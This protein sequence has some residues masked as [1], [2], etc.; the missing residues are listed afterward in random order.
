ME[1]LRRRIVDYFGSFYFFYSYLRFKV[2]VI[3]FLSIL[4]GVL[5]GFGLAMFIPLL[6]MVDSPDSS[7]VDQLGNLSF[8]ITW[9]SEL[10]IPFNLYSILVTI[11]IFFGLKG[12]VKFLEGYLR[13]VY[14]Q[15]FIRQIRVQNADDLA[16]FKYLS[17]I[18]S[19]NGRIQN[20]FSAEVG[21]VNYAFGAYFGALQSAIMVAVYLALAFLTNA[22]F[23]I[24]ISIGGGV[25]NL[26]FKRLYKSTKKASQEYT[27]QS[28]R[29]QGLLIQKVA[30]FKYLKATGLIFKYSEKLK[31]RIFLM[32]RL[33]RRMGILDT[34]MQAVREPLI[35]LV[36]VTVIMI[37]VKFFSEALG[38]IIL[39]LLLFYRALSF[40]MSVQKQWNSFLASS[41]AL[42]NMTKFISE[43][44]NG[45]E[46]YGETILDD[47]TY[48]LELKDIKFSYADIEVLKDIN[49][50]IR[51]NETI[52]LVGESGSGKTTLINLIAGLI[53]P[54]GGEI[55]IDNKPYT[56]LDVRSV[57]SR[58]GYITQE[59]VIF[60][61]TVFNNVTFWDEPT[62]YNIL[63]FE[64]CLKKAAI[65][66]FIMSLD[67]K[68]NTTLGING[69]NL[70]G[71][72]KQRLSIARELYKEIDLLLM[73]EATSALDSETE[74]IIQANI[75][76][77]KG[78][79][80]IIIIAHRLSTIKN[81][82]R[83]VM[84]NRGVIDGVGE[85]SDLMEKSKRFSHMV[86]LQA[87]S[88]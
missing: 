24:L 32:E 7:N 10:N 82:D 17:F 20:T 54:L 9:L 14:Q 81:A 52:A 66:D 2:L 79:Y 42:E 58:I 47:F 6:Q 72:Q 45:K 13:V 41:G 57:Q 36:V 53:E 35:M 34:T 16:R 29:F 59:P 12:G 71:G 85:F 28:H 19:D 83:I 30:N 78:K 43:L 40:L 26:L 49:L 74:R 64:D 39:S 70:S 68:E 73:D 31:E 63:R 76:N 84:L 23:A 18:N 27:N 62:T 4:V 50:S 67:M 1:K 87:F 5:D 75:E 33:Q 55:L 69:V 80:T 37:Q 88:D 22:Q 25:T 60:S 46:S 77:L 44:K 61:D 65:Y 51:K 11:L 15:F 86:G 56:Y 38:A 48:Q 8:L 21:R 3:L